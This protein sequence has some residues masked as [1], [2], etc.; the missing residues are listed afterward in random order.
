M[1]GL[2][3]LA[4]L[5]TSYYFIK[6]SGSDEVLSTPR[7]LWLTQHPWFRRTW[8]VIKVILLASLVLLHV[9]IFFRLGYTAA[10]VHSILG[11]TE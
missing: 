3:S 1:I 8:P 2:C 4:A 9:D 6:G 7:F 5:V 10:G 11:I